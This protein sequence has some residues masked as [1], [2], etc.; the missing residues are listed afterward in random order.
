MESKA[1]EAVA[2]VPARAI[3]PRRLSSIL[4]ELAV[5]AREAIT[6][7]QIRDAMGDRGF[8]ALLVVF[9]AVNMLPLPPG[10]TLVLGLPL[11]LVALQMVLGSRTAWLPRFLLDKSIAV[12]RFRGLSKRAVPYLRWIERLIRP[13]YWPFARDGAD[14]VIGMIALVLAIAVTLPIPF[15]NW[16]P[17]FSCALVGLALSERDGLLLSVAVVSGVMSLALMGVVVGAAGALAAM[18]LG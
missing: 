5:G 10:A 2:G 4:E 6:V 16:F 12:E 15:G 13:R 14:R 3:P 18:V 17:A 9:S 8:A 1:R 11:L 7:A